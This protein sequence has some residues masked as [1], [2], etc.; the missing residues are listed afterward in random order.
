M[1][2]KPNMVI[3]GTDAGEQADVSQIVEM[4]IACLKEVV[5]NDVPGIVFLSGG[6]SERQA[7]ETLNAMNE[8]TDH[9]PWELS[10]SYGRALQTS[11][12]EAWGGKEEHVSDAQRAFLHRAMLTSNARSGI[13]N[14]AME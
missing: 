4:T 8:L 13:Y 14:S 1:L 2:L 5:P 10:F 6:Q 3:S 9:G 11:A 7:C 12:L